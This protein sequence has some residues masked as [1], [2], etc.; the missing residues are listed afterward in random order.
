MISPSYLSYYF[1]LSV[2]FHGELSTWQCLWRDMQLWERWQSIVWSLQSADNSHH[3]LSS[4]VIHSIIACFQRCASLV[5]YGEICSPCNRR[6]LNSAVETWIESWRHCSGRNATDLLHHLNQTGN[7][8]VHCL[9]MWN[10]NSAWETFGTSGRH[11]FYKVP[12]RII[13]SNMF[14]PSE[15]LNLPPYEQVS[16]SV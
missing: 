3:T 7:P 1:R 11:S 16:M 14:L 8:Y 15:R 9:K 2:S 5:M 4:M 6:L 13:R 12:E 10:M